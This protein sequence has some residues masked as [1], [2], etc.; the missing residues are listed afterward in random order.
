MN[1]LIDNILVYSSCL[2][3]TNFAHARIKGYNVYSTW[4][5]LLTLTSLLIHGFFL[6][7]FTFM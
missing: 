3:I 7:T 1:K 5:Y 6:V 2:F 4:F